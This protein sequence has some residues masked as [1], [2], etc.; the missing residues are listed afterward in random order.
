VR[1]RHYIISLTI[2]LSV[3]FL[4]GCSVVQA[5]SPTETPTQTPQPTLTPTP[6]VTPTAT[7]IPFFVDA[8]VWNADL[9]VPIL[10]YH[11]FVPNYMNTD[12]TQMRL[13]DFR[14]EL[15]LFYDNGF[16]LVSLKGWL[17]GNISLPP[18]RKPLIITL[19]DLWFGNQIFINENGTP[20]TSSGIGVLWQFSQEHPDFGFSAALFAINGDKYYPEKQVGDAFYAADNI[21]FYTKSWHKKLGETI[22]WAMDNGIEVYSHTFEHPWNW[23]QIPNT[24]IQNQLETNDYWLR[25]F[26]HEANRDDLV[27]QLDNMIALPEGKWPESESGKNVVLNYKNT[28]NE[29]VLAVM[30]A[31]NF[32]DA[33]LTPSVFSGVLDPFHIARITAS[34]YMT[35]YIIDNK[36]R[37]PTLNTCKLG[38]LDEA[39][40]GNQEALQTAIQNVVAAQACPE[41]VYNVNGYVFLARGGTVT[42]HRSVDSI[43]VSMEP[44]PT[45]TLAP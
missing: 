21:N 10:I 36:D 30:E 39:L 19:D 26:L 35:Q 4:S 45:L 3:I 7:E 41:G 13:A 43:P 15:Q 11:Q 17:E 24:E 5:F 25:Q 29:P 22:A 9:E 12:A 8:A 14:E 20:S 38:P 34:K 23:S 32:V 37:V 27:P 42:L 16:S 18:G 6:T 44:T 1:T 2:I 31:Y 40:A 28:E 33:R